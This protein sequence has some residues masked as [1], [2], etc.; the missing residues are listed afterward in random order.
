MHSPRPLPSAGRFIAWSLAASLMLAGCGS[1]DEPADQQAQAADSGDDNA[2]TEQKESAAP[3][4]DVKDPMDLAP[5]DAC[6]S[7]SGKTLVELLGEDL[8]K[9]GA[10]LGK[11][12]AG[13]LDKLDH[14]SMS[15]MWVGVNMDPGEAFSFSYDL[16]IYPKPAITEWSLE[17]Y[18]EKADPDVELGDYAFFETN[19]DGK[20]IRLRLIDGQ[21]HLDL[22]YDARTGTD[23]RDAVVSEKEMRKRALTAAEEVLDSVG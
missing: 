17:D 8:K 19:E 22:T 15:C 11:P 4:I 20:R 7:V 3:D 14:L 16:D 13:D 6:T 12:D 23:M 1:P 2:T 5:E 21:A 18:K 9:S 10:D